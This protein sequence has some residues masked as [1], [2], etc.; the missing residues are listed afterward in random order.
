MT[1]HFRALRAM[2]LSMALLAPGASIALADSPASLQA[3]SPAAP[4]PQTHSTA[5]LTPMSTP[6]LAG[7]PTNNSRI[8]GYGIGGMQPLP[9]SPPGIDLGRR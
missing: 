7:T 4:L 5:P 2:A 1:T 3:G 8:A 9:G 6:G